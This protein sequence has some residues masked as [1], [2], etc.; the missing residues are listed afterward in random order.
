MDINLQ[1]ELCV[2]S[3]RA[4]N[5]VDLD[6][7]LVR[8]SGLA[9][10]VY[11][12]RH[13]L[14]HIRKE[15]RMEILEL[16]TRSGQ[17]S[18][19]FALASAFQPLVDTQIGPAERER[20]VMMIMNGYEREVSGPT[21]EDLM[22][23]REMLSS[24]WSQESGLTM[25][26]R[27]IEY[28]V[29]PD[30][31][32]QSDVPK[33]VAR[34]FPGADGC[35]SYTVK[36]DPEENV[37]RVYHDPMFL[38][39]RITIHAGAEERF[40]PHLCRFELQSYGGQRIC[41]YKCIAVVKLR[42]QPDEPDKIRLYTRAGRVFYPSQTPTLPVTY[43]W[44]ASQEGKYIYVYVQVSQ[45]QYEQI[46]PLTTDEPRD[47]LPLEVSHQI[48]SS[49]DDFLRQA[50]GL[51]PTVE[52][53]HQ[54]LPDARLSPTFEP[55]MPPAQAQDPPASMP[56][57]PREPDTALTG[58]HDF[59]VPV[60]MGNQNRAT[61]PPTAGDQP[62]A[63][64]RPWSESPEGHEEPEPQRTWTPAAPAHWNDRT[65]RDSSRNQ[66]RGGYQN[67]PQRGGYQNQPQRGGY[68]NQA[69]R[70]GRGPSQNYNHSPPQAYDDY[71][72]NTN[73]GG[74]HPN[75]G[76]RPPRDTYRPRDSQPQRRQSN[77]RE[78]PK[79]DI[80]DGIPFE[81]RPWAGNKKDSQDPKRR[82]TPD[83]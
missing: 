21:F 1:R 40:H 27:V 9:C 74:G 28:R 12:I 67:Q 73:R 4:E 15:A 46:C 41:Y 14:G 78:P 20:I 31:D 55:S 61:T 52:P 75:R 63:T 43:D 69:P 50:L 42:Q 48:E 22:N 72:L 2:E 33:N 39:I 34:G 25:V 79:G 29:H 3:F 30:G 32:W 5:L 49:A 53:Q 68:H 64:A 62:L 65:G 57:A 54:P 13:M 82:K 60:G 56:D 70:G 7:D 38:R 77:R 44:R 51:S 11:L 71:R 66:Q 23:S 37:T 83:F 35:L 80:E 59:I 76:S 16:A 17:F 81:E 19:V 24:V 45:A 47:D 58:S 6:S 10:Q 26:L 36:T 8:R 18:H